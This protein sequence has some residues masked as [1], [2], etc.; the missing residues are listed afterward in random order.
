VAVEMDGMGD[1]VGVLDYPEGVFVLVWDLNDTEFGILHE[2]IV[3]FT[4]VLEGRFVP[5]DVDRVSMD[6]RS[7]LM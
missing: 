1:A 6:V 4:D 2:E 5:I 7:N 3:S